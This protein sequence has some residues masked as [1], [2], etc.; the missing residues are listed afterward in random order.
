MKKRELKR[1]NWDEAGISQ[2]DQ[3]SKNQQKYIMGGYGGDDGCCWWLPGFPEED[4]C[5]ISQVDAF[6][7]FFYIVR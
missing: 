3:I 4:Q 7:L 6:R 1:F 2:S 5:C